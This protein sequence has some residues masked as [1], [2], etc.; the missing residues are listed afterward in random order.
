MI[1]SCI[2]LEIDGLSHPLLLLVMNVTLRI[3]DE[4]AE[5]LAAGARHSVRHIARPRRFDSGLQF[6]RTVAVQQ[7]QQ[8]DGDG[9]E[10]TATLRGTNQQG[11]AAGCRLHQT[12]LPDVD[13]Q[14][15]SLAPDLRYAADLRSA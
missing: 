9:A 2:M 7:P 13:A 10:I 15:V 14:R 6:G 5:R 11:L 12:R 3:P 1:T 4:L 8:S